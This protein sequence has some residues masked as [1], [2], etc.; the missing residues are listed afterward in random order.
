MSAKG[1]LAAIPGGRGVSVAK[2]DLPIMLACLCEPAHDTGAWVSD[3][4]TVPACRYRT[5]SAGFIISACI[6]RWKASRVRPYGCRAERQW[7]RACREVLAGVQRRS[8]C[9][10]RTPDRCITLE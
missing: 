5:V 2:A 6:S 8:V 3:L 1:V 10:Y 9:G 7:N 4:S